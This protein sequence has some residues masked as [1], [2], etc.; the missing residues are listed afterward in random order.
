MTGILTGGPG[1]SVTLAHR[2]GFLHDMRR[3][4]D[5]E[6]E[7]SH[8]ETGTEFTRKYKGNPIVVNAITS[9]HGDVEPESAIAVI[10]VAA[11]ALSPARPGACNESTESHIKHPRDSEEI[12]VSFDGV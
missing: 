5:R 12:A 11:G 8:V 7:G 6:V 9:Y 2:V 4:V 3:A 1:E 10:V